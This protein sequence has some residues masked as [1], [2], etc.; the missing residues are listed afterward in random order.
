ML[1]VF[2]SGYASEGRAREVYG[3]RGFARYMNQDS[4]EVLLDARPYSGGG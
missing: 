2:E 3:T 4:V 1:G